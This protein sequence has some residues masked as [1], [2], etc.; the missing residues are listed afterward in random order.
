MQDIIYTLN[1]SLKPEIVFTQAE[2]ATISSH[3][4]QEE[5]SCIKRLAILKMM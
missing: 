2:I 5:N 1:I 4:I 3:V